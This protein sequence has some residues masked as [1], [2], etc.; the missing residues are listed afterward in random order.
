MPAHLVPG[1]AASI[2]P[3][4]KRD[5]YRGFTLSS[6]IAKPRAMI[7]YGGPRACVDTTSSRGQQKNPCTF[8]TQDSWHKSLSECVVL[9]KGWLVHSNSA[10]RQLCILLI[11][12]PHRGNKC[13]RFAF[14]NNRAEMIESQ[15]FRVVK[16]RRYYLFWIWFIF[17]LAS[18]SINVQFISLIV[19]LSS[20]GP[21][22]NTYWMIPSCKA[23]LKDIAGSKRGI[24]HAC[25]FQ[26]WGE[27]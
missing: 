8:W 26:I 27:K 14:G 20:F 19:S 25:V 1:T 5:P 13:D 21:P 12:G 10:N 18:D 9:F 3:Q 2:I 17:T 4:R 23:V 11:W 16:D 7:S 15:Y 22:I 6:S 24:I